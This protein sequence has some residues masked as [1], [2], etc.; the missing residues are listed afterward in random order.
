MFLNKDNFFFKINKLSCFEIKPHVAVGVSGGPDSM[1]LVYFVNEWIKEKKGKLSALIFDHGIRK[2]SKDES[3]DVR[4]TLQELKINSFIIKPRSKIIKKSM[5]SARYNRFDGLVSF[6][7]KNNIL[8]LFLGHHFDDN[9]ET[10]LIR[11][12][13]GSNLEGLGSMNCITYFDRIQIIRPLITYNKKSIIDFNNQ[14]K[15]RFLHDPSNDDI[16]FTRVKVR[17]FLQKTEN[18]NL[19]KNDFN[20]IK[21]KIPNYKRMIWESLSKNLIKVNSDKVRIRFDY[22]LKNDDLIIEK[23]ILIILKFF[24]SKNYKTKSSKINLL[25]DAIKKPEFKLFNVSSIIV[26]KYGDFLIFSEK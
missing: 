10:Y 13:N 15:V 16:N 6:C 9:L 19:V 24:S 12:L 4:T 21:K 7:K 2:D 11:R 3:V 14:N 25:I 20:S 1:A 8:H 5:A 18:Y 26:E 23:H 22:L 17:K